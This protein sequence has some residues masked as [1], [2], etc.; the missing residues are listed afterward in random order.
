MVSECQSGFESRTNG[1]GSE[2]AGGI[3]VV[4]VLLMGRRCWLH[5]EEFAAAGM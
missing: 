3:L 5:S 4:M 1:V 2:G